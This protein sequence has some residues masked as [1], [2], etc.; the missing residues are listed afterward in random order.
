MSTDRTQSARDSHRRFF[1]LELL[2][3]FVLETS[4]DLAHRAL[5]PIA[6]RKR[7]LTELDQCIELGAA[8]GDQLFDRLLAFVPALQNS[9]SSL[10]AGAPF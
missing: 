1:G 2:G 10:C 8:V 5:D 9:S 3:G 4:S 6:A 7:I